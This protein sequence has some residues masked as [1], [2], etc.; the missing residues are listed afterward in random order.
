MRCSIPRWESL[1]RPPCLL[2]VS[3]SSSVIE[4]SQWPAA[5]SLRLPGGGPTASYA[6]GCGTGPGWDRQRG[7]FIP[8]DRP[9]LFLN[10]CE[11]PSI[12]L[13]R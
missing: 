2:S 12:K 1:V 9:I 3:N 10:E 6:G 8:A 7:H 5:A 11:S 13:T 4:G